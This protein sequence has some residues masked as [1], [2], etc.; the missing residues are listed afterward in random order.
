[1]AK[2]L[3]PPF[4]A[5]TKFGSGRIAQ[6]T[7]S[8]SIL[9]AAYHD[10]HNNLVRRGSGSA[11]FVHLD[12]DVS[13]LN[14]IHQYLW[15]AGRPTSARPLHRQKMMER[16]ILIT[17]QADLHL[18]WHESRIFLKPLPDY[19]L[20]YQFWEETICNDAALHASSCGFLL[21][22]VW[23]LCHPSDLK[24]ALELGLLSPGISWED[25]T[26]FV[27][28]FL[29]HIDYE[30]LDMINKRYRYG[31]LRLSRLNTIHRLTHIFELEHCVRGYMY[32]YNRYTVF[33]ERNFGWV[34]IVF[35]YVTIILTAMQVGLG[36]TA[37][38]QDQMF[39]RAS[40][41]FAVF[42][43]VLPVCVIGVGLLLFSWFFVLN[44]VAT[45]AFLNSRRHQRRALIQ[46]KA[47]QVP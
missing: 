30:A 14:K 21:S 39:Q 32:G 36:T 37:L 17:E 11:A 33:F 27:D 13:R 7:R 40:Y 42:S 22:Y 1:M 9:P 25:W 24:I 4:P 34:I 20:D 38:Q 29:L 6:A 31:E 45:K 41:G 19:I 10:Q 47:A 5:S 43:I 46:S 12:M 3:S 35:L 2:Q 8:T 23:L 26:I 18:V 16:Q 15:L 28:T 44:L